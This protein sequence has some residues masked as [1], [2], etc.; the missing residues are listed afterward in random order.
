MSIMKLRLWLVLISFLALAF[1]MP[2]QEWHQDILGNG[3]EYCNVQQPSDYSGPVQS[4]VIRK[5]SPSADGKAVLYVHG[6]NDYFFQ[7]EMADR[8]VAQG[9]NFYAVDLRK[10]GRSI[11]PGQH[12][13]EVRDLKEYFA[14]I[15]SALKYIRH[16][17]NYKIILMGHSTGG[18][19]ASYYMA[20]NQAAPV[21]AL[22]L[23]SPFLDWNLG[24]KECVIPVISAISAVFP[25][26]SIS[27][28]DSETYSSSLLRG[29]HGEWSF[30]TDWKLPKSPDVTSGWIRAITV[31]QDYLHHHKYQINVPILLMFSAQSSNSNDWTPESQHTDAVLDVRD[32][33]KYGVTLG[34]YV[35]PVVVKG[36]LHDLVLSAPGVRNSV[37]K[38]LFQWLQNV[39]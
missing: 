25:N 3:F 22:V 7:S 24:W 37:Y 12:L 17:R 26:I 27:Q 33:Y 19:I 13:F 34:H 9:Y 31:A 18:L 11:M 38:Y 20:L 32:I 14:D 39:E 1:R 5:L 29:K 2:A 36:G 23:N 28:G 16:E 21:D 4:S 35:K 6:F 8:F 10:Y 30:D 15:D